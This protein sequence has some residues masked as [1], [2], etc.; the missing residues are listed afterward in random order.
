[1]V[2][3]LALEHKFQDTSQCI[4]R[5]SK[6]TLQL[7]LLHLSFVLAS[8]EAPGAPSSEAPVLA[9]LLVQACFRLCCEQTRKPKSDTE[10]GSM[11]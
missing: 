7:Y 2:N 1:M 10:H 9:V 11:H 8:F 5:S 3:G 4:I 6:C